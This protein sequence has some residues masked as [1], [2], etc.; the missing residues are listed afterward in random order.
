MLGISYIL[1]RSPYVQTALVKYVTERI[2]QVTG[3]KMQI[4][5]VEFRPMSSLV[6]NDVLLRDFKNDTL[7]FCENLKVKADSFSFV[8]RSFTVREMTFNKACFKAIVSN[9][10]R[11]PLLAFFLWG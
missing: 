5:G 6:L 9:T 2:E 3:V 11:I 4:G 1:L 8:N 10:H 7:V